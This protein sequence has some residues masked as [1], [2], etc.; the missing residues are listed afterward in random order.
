MFNVDAELGGVVVA[1]PFGL[2]GPCKERN[3]LSAVIVAWA[4]IA[5]PTVVLD[6]VIVPS[7]KYVIKHNRI[8]FTTSRFP[9]IL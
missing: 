9:A 4:S 3:K 1:G 8:P 6:I 2:A 7:E 5:R